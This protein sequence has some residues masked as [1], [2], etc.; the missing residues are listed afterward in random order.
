MKKLIQA[1][2]TSYMPQKKK[3]TQQDRLRVVVTEKIG[4][5]V[6]KQLTHVINI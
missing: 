5:F 3:N 1:P 4:W 6:V 2:L